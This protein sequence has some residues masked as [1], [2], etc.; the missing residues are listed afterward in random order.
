MN[1]AKPKAAKL[2]EV[3]SADD[4]NNSAQSKVL[5]SKSTQEIT[6]PA[7]AIPSIILKNTDDL[8]NF[9]ARHIVLIK[10]EYDVKIEDSIARVTIRRTYRN[11]TNDMFNVGDMIP[12]SSR[13]A[14]NKFILYYQG[15]AHHGRTHA[16][17]QRNQ[18]N[19]SKPSLLV[20][21]VRD[22][23][24]RAIIFYMPIATE[25]ILEMEYVEILTSQSGSYE[26]ILP[27]SINPR[28]IKNIP[29]YD[30][31]EFETKYFLSKKPYFETSI[32][33]SIKGKKEIIFVDSPTHSFTEEVN[34]H[35]RR[36]L[37]ID[38]DNDF[39]RD[40]VLT[41]GM[42][43]HGIATALFNTI[44]NDC[45]FY[46][47]IYHKFERE[48]KPFPL[49]EF[50]YVIEN[51]IFT[52]D[53]LENIQ[54][55]I[56]NHIQDLRGVDRINIIAYNHKMLGLYEKSVFVSDDLL[57]DL[58]KYFESINPEHGNDLD[59][60]LEAI[61]TD[62][63]PDG[64]ERNVILFSTGNVEDDRD[65]IRKYRESLIAYHIHTIGLGNSPN[66]YL[67]NKLSNVSQGI[68]MRMIP[69][70]KAE[71]FSKYFSYSLSHS[72][73]KSINLKINNGSTVRQSIAPDTLMGDKKLA[74]F[75]KSTKPIEKAE[76][77]GQINGN[78]VLDKI[79]KSN[80]H[81]LDGK[82]IMDYYHFLAVSEIDGD[83]VHNYNK[84]KLRMIQMESNILTQLNNVSY[85]STTKELSYKSR[86]YFQAITINPDWAENI[87]KVLMSAKYDSFIKDID[88]QR[89][90][91]EGLMMRRFESFY[92]YL[93]SEIVEIEYSIFSND[94]ALEDDFYDFFESS[95]D[96]IKWE[97]FQAKELMAN[98]FF[99]FYF[100]IDFNEDLKIRHINTFKDNPAKVHP[101]E[102]LIN[103]F[104]RY[105]PEVEVETHLPYIILSMDVINPI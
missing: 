46:A 17:V 67:L 58:P 77:Y 65:I 41:F 93:D 87:E 72:E 38:S 75:G 60:A 70:V 90:L 53:D 45:Y 81:Y 29:A 51:S 55:F 42:K 44:Y 11:D 28:Y 15:M 34:A 24:C 2:K 31:Y 5:N 52:K 66:S 35:N 9:D 102:S 74:V 26:L 36:T 20:E 33:V 80:I 3:K 78:L 27:L 97:V 49:R 91:H 48:D 62:D 76:F 88:L 6:K 32:N 14:L 61:Y 47:A 103:I 104:S 100:V 82:D 57:A 43:G 37:S 85:N 50:I 94:I 7:A 63:P 21:R 92:R 19:K 83:S 69:N 101:S 23:I 71:E 39:L 84:E 10:S 4:S 95:I 12:V 54:I 18:I 98:G 25:V 22:N 105:E 8:K 30:D 79:D 1:K 73:Y 40:F 59:A 13:G 56:E 64:Y 16:A 99:N 86:V 96:A 68:A 89:K